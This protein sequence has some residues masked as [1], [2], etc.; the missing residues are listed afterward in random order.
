MSVTFNISLTAPQVLSPLWESTEPLG[1]GKLQQHITPTLDDCDKKLKESKYVDY[2]YGRP[3]KT[4]FSTFPKLSSFLY[5]RDAGKG[6]MQAVADKNAVKIGTKQ[7]LSS[8]EKDD[9]IDSSISNLE[10][11]CLRTGDLI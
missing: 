7:K 3:I 6:I 9:L 10:V 2:F 11:I 5:D 4:D 8:T 1:L